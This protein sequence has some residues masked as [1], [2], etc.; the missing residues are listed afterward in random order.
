MSDRDQTASRESL[1][2]ETRQ[3]VTP[4]CPGGSEIKQS[5]DALARTLISFTYGAGAVRQSDRD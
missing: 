1:S 3:F 4:V 5:A 2:R